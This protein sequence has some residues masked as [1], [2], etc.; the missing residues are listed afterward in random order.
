[1]QEAGCRRP[2]RMRGAQDQDVA[3]ATT[4]LFL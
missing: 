3:S 1:M 2:D 4:G